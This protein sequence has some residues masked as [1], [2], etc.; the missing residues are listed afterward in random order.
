MRSR[1]LKKKLLFFLMKS[2]NSFKRL[3]RSRPV[4]SFQNSG[5][6]IKTE[7]KL[8]HF[9]KIGIR[10]KLSENDFVF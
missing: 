1:A 8:I 4:V 7:T 6:Q 10:T 9:L 3:S 2:V 5:N